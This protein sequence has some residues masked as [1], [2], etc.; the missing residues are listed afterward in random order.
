MS[1]LVAFAVLVGRLDVIIDLTID[2]RSEKKNRLVRTL[3]IEYSRKLAIALGP[4][5]ERF[6][7]NRLESSRHIERITHPKT[8]GQTYAE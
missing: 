6:H 8:I 5:G 3:V 4:G 1:V 2:L 7:F